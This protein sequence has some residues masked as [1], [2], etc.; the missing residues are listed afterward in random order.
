[1]TQKELHALLQAIGYPV[2]FYAFESPPPLPYL[3][4]LDPT[5]D[6]F[7]ADNTNYL[8]LTNWQVELYTAIS[9]STGDRLA[10]ELKIEKAF[11]ES[12]IPYKRLRERLNEEKM[13]Q[14]LYTIQTIGGR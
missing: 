10:A 5:S 4:Y 13:Y 11:K 14:T 12:Q 9:M 7:V 3:V 6:D 1:V 8:D 2:A